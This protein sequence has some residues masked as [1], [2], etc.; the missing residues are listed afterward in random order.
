MKMKTNLLRLT[1]LL[2]AG[3]L[4]TFAVMAQEATVNPIDTLT[5]T[6]EKLQ[7]DVAVMN[8]LKITGYIQAQYQTADTIGSPAGFSGGNF[9][10][11][12]NRFMVRRGRIKF[13]YTNE[14]SNYVL[15]FDVTEKGLGIKDAYLSLTDP[16][17]KFFTVTGGVFDRPFGYEISYSSSNRETPERSRIFQTLFPGERDCGAKLTIQA[18]K[19]SNWNF[20]KL[21]AGL[22]GGNGTNV[23]TDKYKDFIGHLSATKTLLNENLSIGGGVSY[24]KGGFA[25]GTTNLY[26]MYDFTFSDGTVGKA[27]LARTVTAGSQLKREYYGV[28]AQLSYNSPIGITTIRGEYIAGQQPATAGSSTSPTGIFTNSQTYSTKAGPDPKDATKT[29]YTTTADKITN[30]DAYLRY[31]TG[32]YVY[33]I[34]SIMQTK[35]EVVAKYDWYD[36]NNQVDGNKIAYLSTYDAAKKTVSNPSKTTA[37]DLK[38][39]TIGL[40]LIY[41]W[42]SNIK[43]TGYYEIVNNETTDAA[44]YIASNSNVGT[45]VI[46]KDQKDNVFTLRVQYKF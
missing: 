46:N 6:V 8:R 20:I 11:L 23:E 19:T 34:Q 29:I 7:S 2:F 42:N 26:K 14:L 31:F 33:F 24:Y 25:S 27:F 45:S 40:G 43:I 44:G 32:G 13:A 39:N 9:S 36:P 21:E 18:P 3:A 12:D 17:T 16:W 41:H 5:G 28:D 37:T 15:Q 4:S 35:W 10:G 38:Y 1:S 30:A 22:F